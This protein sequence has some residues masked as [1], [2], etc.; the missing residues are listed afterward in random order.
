MFMGGIVPVAKML[1]WFNSNKIF[2]SFV[3]VNYCVKKG[4]ELSNILYFEKQ[5]F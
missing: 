5:A 1:I 2:L 3:V 4:F